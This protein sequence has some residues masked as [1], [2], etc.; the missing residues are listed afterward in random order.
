MHVISLLLGLS[1]LLL[2]ACGESR[3]EAVHVGA[4]YNF[5]EVPVEYLNEQTEK[6][7]NAVFEDRFTF[8]EADPLMGAV[9]RA[10]QEIVREGGS[11]V[12]ARPIAQNSKVIQ[13][14]IAPAQEARIREETAAA[15]KTAVKARLR[16]AGIAPGGLPLFDLLAIMR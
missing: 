15:R 11:H 6:Y 12:L 9:R 8:E 14:R 2:T 4:T 10:G 13:I 1:A 3:V 16:F 7:L 5:L